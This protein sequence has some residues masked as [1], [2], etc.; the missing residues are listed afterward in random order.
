M[1]REAISN[2]IDARAT[3][4]KIGFEVETI[5]GRK[6]LVIV[7]TDNGAGMTY[8]V[9]GKDFWGLGYSPSR[10]RDDAI[11]EKGH[12][13]KIY[14]RSDK[15][16]VKTQ[17]KEGD[18]LSECENPLA[19]LS[20]KKLH[21]PRI[22]KIDRFLPKDQTGT[23]IRIEGYND[24]ERSKFKQDFVRDYILWFTKIGSIE[25]EFSIETYK[26]F[27][28]ELK[29]LDRTEFETVKFGHIFPKPN[30]DIDK[31]FDQYGLEAA[32]LYVKRHLWAGQRLGAYP[33]V[34]YDAV[35]YVEGDQA[36]R[37]YNPMIKERMRSDTGR[38]KVG[39]RYGLWLCKDFIPVVRVND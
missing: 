12:G 25:K 17:S 13:T 6:K 27:Q 35:V 7:I 10:E 22:T 1:L 34:T 5:D 21:Q 20:S 24:S 29:C 30:S 19:T 31:L 2:A 14:L 33:E 32:D 18:Y 38:Y 4:M 16:I 3:K 8:S 39:D 11:G 15:I 36:K 28:L 37:T 23:T 9:L 26:N